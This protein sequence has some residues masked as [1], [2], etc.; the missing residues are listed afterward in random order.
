MLVLPYCLIRVGYGKKMPK[1][2]FSLY[3]YPR[4]ECDNKC[5]GTV[6]VAMGRFCLFGFLPKKSNDK[7]K[8][9]EQYKTIDG[10]KLFLNLLSD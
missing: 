8:I 10:A 2:K 7:K 6:G 3:S 9:L 1:R 5:I 4:S